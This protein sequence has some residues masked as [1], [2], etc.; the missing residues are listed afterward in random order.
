MTSISVKKPM[1]IVLGFWPETENFD[2]GKKTSQ[3]EQN[4][5]NPV[6]SPALCSV[7]SSVS[8]FHY[9]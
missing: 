6:S 7:I 9:Q 8:R 4:D 3:G 5:A 1:T 2:F